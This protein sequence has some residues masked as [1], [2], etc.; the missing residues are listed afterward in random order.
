ML[1]EL[2]LL[3][4][5]PRPSSTLGITLIQKG[6]FRSHDNDIQPRSIASCHGPFV[7]FLAFAFEISNIAMP[8]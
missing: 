7:T 1:P 3:P 8:A 2:A 4:L 5:L 6:Q